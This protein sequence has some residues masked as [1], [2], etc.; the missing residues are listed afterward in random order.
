MGRNIAELG[1]QVPEMFLL[2]KDHKSW[3]G[4]AES[5]IPTRPVLSGNNCINT[6]LSELVSELI[7]P[8]SMRLQ[9]AEINSTEEALNKITNLNMNIRNN[10]NWL[11]I[12]ESNVI[13]QMG[14]FRSGNKLEA[15][16]ETSHE[17]LQPVK[18]D[19]SDYK[20]Q[21]E[22]LMEILDHLIVT[23]CEADNIFGQ[24]WWSAFPSPTSGWGWIIP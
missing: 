3:S 13:S 23:G 15:Q 9:G 7:E 24:T 6:H 5:A 22:N 16:P 11:R 4:D 1:Y 12:P 14:E 17:D 18:D 10:G 19:L 8:I 21:E 2:V 20:E